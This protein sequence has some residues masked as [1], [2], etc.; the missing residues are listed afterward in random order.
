MLLQCCCHA[1]G[2]GCRICAAVCMRLNAV[3]CRGALFLWC[4]VEWKN[5]IVQDH[6]CSR[7]GCLICNSSLARFA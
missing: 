1:C 4:R 5:S 7:A 6:R 2:A 3:V